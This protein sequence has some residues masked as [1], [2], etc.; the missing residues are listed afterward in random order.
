MT[1]GMLHLRQVCLVAPKLAPEVFDLQAILGLPVCV[2]DFHVDIYGLTNALL[3]VGNDFIEI[4]APLRKDT[5]AGRFIERS[6][7]RGA[8]MAIFECDDP[9]RRE[10]HVHSMGIRTPHIIDRP[11][12]RNVQMHPKDC[13]ATILEFAR[14][15]G[16]WWPAGP[17]W[18]PATDNAGARLIGLRVTSPDPVRFASHWAGIVELPLTKH[19]DTPAS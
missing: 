8:Y 15:N 1:P 6:E 11:E 18:R 17:D 12:Y 9:E 19:D 2:R 13:G 16:P 4:V 7:G 3:P 10:A 5:A 14:S